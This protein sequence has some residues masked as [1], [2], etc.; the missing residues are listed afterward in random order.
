MCRWTRGGRVSRRHGQAA[1]SGCKILADW[2]LWMRPIWLRSGRSGWSI[3]RR[4]GCSGQSIWRR[5]GWG[6]RSIGP[7]LLSGGPLR[8]LLCRKLSFVHF[9]FGALRLGVRLR[10]QTFLFHGLLNPLP[11]PF[12][13]LRPRRRKVAVLSA[14]QIRPREKRRHVF[15]GPVLVELPF[16]LRHNLFQQLPPSHAFLFLENPNA[17]AAIP[18][19]GKAHPRW[20]LCLQVI[21]VSPSLDEQ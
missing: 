6:G 15:R 17:A 5:T 3:W 18:N 19:P 13:R 7:R 1:Q 21:V 16:A 4:T 20:Q 10:P 9:A 2:I 8:S 12:A 11:G 14:V